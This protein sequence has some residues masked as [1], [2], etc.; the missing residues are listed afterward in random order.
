MPLTLALCEARLEGVEERDIFQQWNL[1]WNFSSSFSDLSY[2]VKENLLKC[3]LSI[4]FF[5]V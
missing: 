1:R 3:F 4:Q 5:N 2:S